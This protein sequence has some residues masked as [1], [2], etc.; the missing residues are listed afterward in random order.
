MHKSTKVPW[1]GVS[2]FYLYKLPYMFCIPIAN[3]A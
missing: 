1:S 2:A 3:F